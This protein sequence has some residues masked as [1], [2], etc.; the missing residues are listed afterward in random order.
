MASRLVIN[1]AVIAQNKGRPKA[2]YLKGFVGSTAKA[3]ASEAWGLA[4]KIR[5]E[6][7]ERKK[8]KRI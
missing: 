7:K 5:A 8:V 2:A 3:E 6:T 4:T 1:D